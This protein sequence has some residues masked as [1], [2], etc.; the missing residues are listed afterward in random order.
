VLPFASVLL[1]LF[2]M[3]LT[4][5][6]VAGGAVSVPI[7][8]H[9][10]NRRRFRVVHWAAMR[11]LLS[12]QRKNARRMRLEQLILLVARCLILL[13]TALAMMAVTP[14]AEGVWRW[15]NPAGGKGILAG[16]A[17]THKVLVL[18][19]SFSMGVKMGDTTAF[20][21]A[22]ALAAQLVE[23]GNGNDAC[24]VVLM[25][26]PPRRIVPRPSEDSRKV[27]AEVRALKMTHGNADLPATLATVASLL[28]E[29]PGKFTNREVYFLTDLQ[30]SGWI[31]P[32]PGDLT[33]AL[34]AFKETRARAIFVDVGQDG[35]S[36]LAVTGLEL[37]EPIATTSGETR[38]L[39]TLFN[40]GDSR[41]D[42]NVRLFVGKARAA[43][44]E[45]PLAVR[46]VA[47]QT[48]RARRNQQTPVPFVYRFPAP[49]DYLIQVQVGHD[50]LELDD[51]RSAVVRV[52]N[53][54]PV[55]LVD[56]KPASEL[57]DRAAQWLRVALNPFDE[58]E[59]TPASIAARPRTINARQLSDAGMGDLTSYDAVYLCDV[60]LV[61]TNEVKR[62][63]AHV[64]RGGAL[65]VCL[66]P[67]VDVN[68]YNDLL[69]RNGEGLLPARL[70]D[71]LQSASKG[72]A[73]Q[74]AMPPEAD[75]RDPLRLFQDAAARERLL[76]PH[77][78]A[79]VPTEL[80]KVGAPAGATSLSV[81]GAAP[82]LVLN[83]A[84]VPLP[85]R[86]AAAVRSPSP[87]PGGP[88]IIEWRP[89]L[90]GRSG[91]QSRTGEEGASPSRLAVPSSRGRVVLITTPVNSDWSNWP[92]SPAFP[93][94]MQEILYHAAAARL[95]ER[96]LLVGEPIELHRADTATGV[97]ATVLVPRDPFDTAP[98]EDDS[99]RRIAS[100]PLADGSV[101]RFGDT[102]VSGVYTLV[103]GQKPA[104]HLF[105]VNVPASSEDQ[106]HSESNLARTSK[107]ELERTYP[108][109]DL[110]VVTELGQVKHAQAQSAAGEVIYTPQGGGIAHILLLVVLF[111]VL[112]EVVMA[113]QFG[114]YSSAGALTGEMVTR[115]AGAWQVLAWASPWLLFAFLSVIAFVLIHD[116]W[117]GDFLGFLPDAVR[118]V[119]ER[120][121]N[122]A[123]PAPGEGSRWRLE[124][125][126][127][128]WS[129][130]ADVWLAGAVAVLAVA[131]VAVVYAVEGN[132][133]SRA[134][135]VLFVALRAGIL[136]LLLAVFL[137]QLK[138]YFERQG[139]P[140]VVILIDDSQSMSSHDV[141]RDDA[142]RK[143]ADA[144]AKKA[145]MSEDEKQALARAVAVRAEVAKAS[146]LRLAQTYLLQ[147]GDDRLQAL[148]A[149]RKVRLH[150]YRCST[151]AHRLAEVTGADEVKKAT[152]AIAALEA[153]PAH[154]TSQLGTAVR[155]VLNDFRGSS[156]AA[157]VMLT[158]GVT[159]EGEDLASVSRY[160]AHMGV[161]LYFL[162][163]G[164]SHE[165]RDLYLHD[166]QAEDSIFVN[167]RIIFRVNLTAQGFKNLTIPVTLHEKGKE[168]VLFRKEVTVGD[169]GTVKVQLEHRP[170]EPGE[171]TYV[172]RVP[173]QPDEIDRD[174]NAL[175][176]TIFVRETKQVR[177]LYVEGYRRYEYQYVKTLLERESARLKGNKSIHLRVLLLDAD[178]DFPLEDRTAIG[179]FPTPFRN[180]EDHKKDDDLW[181]Y[182]VVILGDVDPEPRGDNKMTE[183]LKNVAELVRERGGGL[184]LLAGERFGPRAYKNSPLKDVLPIDVTGA[185]PAN[186]DNE[187]GITDS[188]RAELTSIGRMHPIFSF[189]PDEKENEEIWSKLKEF[190]WCADGYV[191]KRAAEVLAV[192]PQL[193]SG[194]RKNSKHPLVVQ[195]FAGS[196]RCMFFGFNET[197]RWNW[198]ED[199][200]HYN[201]FWIQ[202]MRYLARSKVGRL[203]LR[204]DRQTPYRRGEPI[205]M[206]V[207]F[208]DDDRPPSPRTEVKVVVE[209]R[210]GGAAGVETRSVKLSKLEGSR[211][212][213]EAVLTQ[214]PEGDYRFWLAEPSARP[215]PQIESKVLAPPGEMERLRMNQ[216]EMEQAARDTQGKFYNLA[217]ADRLLDEL[218]TGHRVPVN[219]PGPPF[220]L[221]NSVFAFILFLALFSSEW[222]LRK[223]K[224]LL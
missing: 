204:L 1:A 122:I 14:W 113:W 196:G 128:L 146:R 138:L 152:D 141:Y 163:V 85:G 29:T 16:G 62:L 6:A 57:F 155:Q 188:Y 214:T 197:W 198:R 115:K 206:T 24:S 201:H 207:R 117:T 221:W 212:T 107:E 168:R 86:S 114:H 41:D 160:A 89:L 102:D 147:G 23:E 133:T 27:A 120:A 173:V 68:N 52:R 223:L 45:K 121:L 131:G 60:P 19:G 28:R 13:L 42:V 218:P 118:G 213:Y 132:D 109:W 39:T 103:V 127:F 21:R 140:D 119:A 32:R 53:D 70:T 37:G 165:V 124:Y 18:D 78:T 177:V 167:D 159:T 56:G 11:F 40:H 65:V 36:N 49:G 195:G 66:G 181:S 95:R 3:P 61:G 183:H 187:E 98:P 217:T 211:G 88:A 139:W 34:T 48:V 143:A 54:V 76:M 73:Y 130:R 84:P 137:P 220:L 46:Q 116:A 189:V 99:R 149:R 5:A 210:G 101:L 97:E 176:K 158:D 208:P 64:R 125:T 100:Q 172:V 91:E 136:L 38:I 25:A 87:P 154:D 104:E 190:F 157:V 171:K 63:E 12:A 174:N 203:E 58:G 144:L 33:P 156:L 126:S 134:V 179:S 145:E 112:A 81:H 200:A 10:L 170:T 175:E 123:P 77:F 50:A 178:S 108:E 111:L 20:E 72:Y 47:E 110:Q 209:R 135:R 22:R 44:G 202:T 71:R 92:A 186:N 9:L 192:H 153:S 83:F 199:Q 17:R 194:D 205:K 193:R 30:R 2:E 216:A 55:L 31:S 8:I 166:L 67:Q 106:Q 93:P 35:L 90:P 180:A 169:N 222:L 219:A 7:I 182:D 105:A 164:D 69:Y 82:R 59:R 184:L 79:F 215:R 43:S 129:P 191:P 150:V 162:G 151:R 185:A 4:A 80:V 142:V 96:A 74:L 94:L 148:L 26:A 51:T 224:N 15:L 75:R 161:A